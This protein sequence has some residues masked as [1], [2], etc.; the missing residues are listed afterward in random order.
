MTA[1]TLAEARAGFRD[2]LPPLL[3][4]VPIGL[5]FG[6]LA[7]GRGL[8]PA[9]VA[10]M[11]ALVFAG[12][13]QFAVLDL[14]AAPVPIGAVAFSTGLINARHLL[15][16]ASL[17]PKI[18][19][20][21]RLVRLVGV[22]VM[23]DENWALAERRARERP[24]TPAYWIGMAV[25]F[26]VNWVVFTTLGA[27][28]GSFLGDPK[29]IGADFAFTALFIGL[30]AGFRA[31]PRAGAVIAASAAAAALAHLAVGSPWHVVSGATAG[32]A[33]AVLLA[34]AAGDPAIAGNPAQ[35]GDPVQ[36]GNPAIAG[37]TEVRP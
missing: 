18:A 14:W 37:K 12:G 29:R 25:P 6:A 33:A 35:A 8:H 13:A 19:G 34:P 10:L 15:M 28:A 36:A 20:F 3:A 30:V 2:I 16:G 26:W 24:L 1:D 17:A 23:A 11:S 5:L 31:A 4:A 22:A 21:P 9:E 32:I 7:V 27:L